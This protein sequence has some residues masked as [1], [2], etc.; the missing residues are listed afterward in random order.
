[1]DQARTARAIRP[2]VL[3]GELE[4]TQPV[5]DFGLPR[6]SGGADYQGLRLLVRLQRM[7]IGYASLT[8]DALVASSAAREIWRQVGPAVNARRARQGLPAV[9]TLTVDGLR[10]EPSLDE[11]VRDRPFVSVVINTHDRPESAAATIRRLCAVRYE[12]YEIIVVDNAPSSDQTRSTIL[13]EF[14]ADPRVRYVREPRQ[15]SSFAKNRGVAEAGGEIIAFTDDDVIV[16]PWW[17]E[18]IVRGFGQADD[19]A[20]VTGLIPSAQLENV[21]QFYFDQRQAWGTACERRIFDLIDH[22]DDSPLYP[23]SA[24]VFGAGANF[25]MTRTALAELGGFDEALGA[26]TRCGGGEDLDVFMRVVLAG[27]RLV[28]EPSAIVAHVHRADLGDL[29]KQMRTYGSG[30]TAALTAVLLHSRRARLELPRKFVAGAIRI[31]AAGERTKAD[32]SLPSGLLGQELR[33]MLHG[34][35]LYVSSRFRLR[36]SAV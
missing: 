29:T 36:R 30:C 32:M 12:Q 27:H 14:G 21:A 10:T 18:G 3:I 16:D 9:S 2:P 8:P 19:V 28:Y 15:G 33:G 35:W 23:Y 20:C 22:R 7:P 34:P 11:D 25:A 6:R 31:A 26:G 13:T 4:L 5:T 17:L 24:G 1:M